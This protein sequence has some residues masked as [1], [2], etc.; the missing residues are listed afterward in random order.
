MK[1][2]AI[3]HVTLVGAGPGD[4]DLISLAGVKA[5]QSAKVVLY[6]AL[7]NK[8]ILKWAPE[9]AQFIFV[10][11]RL[12]Y[13]RFEQDEINYKL[14]SLA[15]KHGSV[16]RLKGGDSFIFGRGAEEMEYVESFGIPTTV[17][18]GISSVTSAG[19]GIG[20]P[21][22]K[23]NVSQSFWVITATTQYHQLSEDIGLAAQ[24]SATVVILMGMS[25][26]NQITDIY[27]S[28][29]RGQE[30][31]AIIQEATLATEKHVVGTMDNIIE[32]VKEKEIKNPAVII[33][34]PVVKDTARLN[35]KELMSFVQKKY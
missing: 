10:G 31:V 20:L 4:P 34:G 1:S 25:R 19:S 24:S 28:I 29:D 9:D 5:L 23:R 35:S 6:D 27:K 11:K 13:K 2:K 33:I 15:L 32:L 26:L 14:V 22:T 17:I 18:P 30:S 16:V 3:A 21:L 7:V 8:E 12:G